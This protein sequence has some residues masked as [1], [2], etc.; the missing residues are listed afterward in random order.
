[1][2]SFACKTDDPVSQYGMYHFIH[3]KGLSVQPDGTPDT[4]V[5]IGYDA[6]G[7]GLFSVSMCQNSELKED[8]GEIVLRNEKYPLFQVPI[9]TYE[10]G[11]NCIAEFSSDGGKYPCISGSK[12]GILI[13]FDIFRL[14]GSLLSGYLDTIE[15]R[16]NGVQDNPVLSPPLVD[17]YE[18]LLFRAV[19]TG[20]REVGAPLIRKSYWPSGKEFAVCLTH[21]VDEFTKTYQWV[22]RPLRLIRRGDFSG[23]NNQMRSLS[24]KLKGHEPYWTFENI[25]QNEKEQDVC[26]TYFILNE[27]GKKSLFR[28]DSWHLYGRSHSLQKPRV[29]ELIKNLSQNGHEIG[30]HGSTFS[31]NDP[32][33]LNREKKEIEDLLGRSVTG[34]RQHRLNLTIPDTWE[35]QSESGFLYDT[36]LGYKAAYGTGFRW[37]TCFPFYPRGTAGMLPLLEIPL[38]LM[39]ITLQNVDN[40]WDVC[41]TAI[42]QVKSRGGVLT[43]LW[44]PAVF[45]DLEYPELG[46]WYWKII[47]AS[48]ESDA[49]I[50]TA[51]EIYLWWQKREATAFECQYT[52]DRLAVSGDFSAG[53]YFDLYVPE[54]KTAEI[55]SD[56]ATLFEGKNDHYVLCTEKDTVSDEIVVRLR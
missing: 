1:M 5:C 34:I 25:Q 3:T 45:N 41:N 22:T 6:D 8:A 20:C 15:I 47:Q 56:N 43:L 24:R 13:G 12:S 26:S 51:Q 38:S 52:E 42:E 44:H 17:F 2:I 30:V 29:I 33:L 32:A 39:D 9:D 28:P 37:G 48:K 36:S 4:G 11:T 7:K 50:T 18:D 27:S 10:A 21:D 23:L 19:L 35:Y 55:I 54:N 16:S 31:Y 53:C 14:T 49:W 40:G 46:D